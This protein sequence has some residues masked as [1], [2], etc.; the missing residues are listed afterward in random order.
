MKEKKIDWFLDASQK[1]SCGEVYEDKAISGHS[2][3]MRKKIEHFVS[4]ANAFFGDPDKLSVLDYGCG[5]GETTVAFEQV[6]GNV[7]GC[8]TSASMLEQARSRSMG[9]MR[10]HHLEGA[11]LPVGDESYHLACMFG[12]MHHMMS[13][14]DI[15]ASFGEIHRTLKSD[16]VLAIYEFNPLNPAA[17]HIVNTCEIDEAVN[18]DGYKKNI[19]PTTFYHWELREILESCS[20][21]VVENDFILIFPYFLKFLFPIEKLFIRLPIGNMSVTFARKVG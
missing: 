16:G 6:F 1:E 11:G 17:R 15:R 9:K 5:T 19:F 8:D 18:L 21:E 13:M 7:V 3:Y 12:V 10:L 2:Y 4:K 20:F 14:D